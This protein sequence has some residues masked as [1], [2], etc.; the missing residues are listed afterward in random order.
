M[1]DLM[2]NYFVIAPCLVKAWLKPVKEKLKSVLIVK[3]LLN[4][5]C[6]QA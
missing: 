1:N 6:V 2:Q 3:A 5:N 4:L